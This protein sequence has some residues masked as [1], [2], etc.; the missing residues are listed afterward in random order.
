M[1]TQITTIKSFNLF[2]DVQAFFGD[3]LTGFVIASDCTSISGSSVVVEYRGEAWVAILKDSDLTAPKSVVQSAEW[4]I[5]TIKTANTSVNAAIHLESLIGGEGR[6]EWDVFYA[7]PFE[8][9]MGAINKFIALCCAN[10]VNP[11]KELCAIG[12]ETPLTPSKAALQW[13]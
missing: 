8:N 9:S 1:S 13:A 10:G 7:N 4:A 6:Y 12:Y 2:S 3:M 5:S 11:V